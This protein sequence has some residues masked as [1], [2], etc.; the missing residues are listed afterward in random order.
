MK[1]ELYTGLVVGIHTALALVLVLVQYYS[2]LAVVK[3]TDL[4]LALAM[5]Q[6]WKAI[7]SVL[8][9]FLVVHTVVRHSEQAVKV[10]GS[11][12]SAVG[13]GTGGGWT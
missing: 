5:T 13:M 9:L 11:D 10:K 6:I 8:V 3:Y 12:A 1:Q 7:Y 2:E 4:L